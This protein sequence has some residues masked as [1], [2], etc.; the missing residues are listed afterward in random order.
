[1]NKKLFLTMILMTLLL[2]TVS[3]V[4]ISASTVSE[5]YG[6][7]TLIHAEK[8]EITVKDRTKILVEA[9]QDMPDFERTLLS[10]KYRT[11]RPAIASVSKKGVVRGKKAGVA[12][13]RVTAIYREKMRAIR[14]CIDGKQEISWMWRNV[15][16][17]KTLRIPV[18][19][20]LKGDIIKPAVPIEIVGGSVRL[21][22]ECDGK[23]WGGPLSVGVGINPETDYKT[24]FPSDPVKEGYI[25]LGWYTKD[26]VKIGTK[27]KD[28]Y[29]AFSNIKSGESATVYAR[30]S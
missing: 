16:E 21:Y 15:K 8:N 24:L 20:K 5:P 14:K 1:M 30:W 11:L 26:G 12:K 2:A 6:R 4:Q 22:F 10:V 28:I 13:I 17:T 3:S 19:R 27:A 7:G 25:F 18:N 29:P 9:K 23:A